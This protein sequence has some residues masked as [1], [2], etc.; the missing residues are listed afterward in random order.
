MVGAQHLGQSD[1]IGVFQVRRVAQ[2]QP[3]RALD[4]PPRSLVMAQLFARIPPV[5]G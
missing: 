5:C 2:Q 3:V 1:L 4:H